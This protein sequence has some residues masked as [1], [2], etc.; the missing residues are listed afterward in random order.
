[1]P[2]ASRSPYYCA[3]LICVLNF[4]VLQTNKQTNKQTKRRAHVK[5]PPWQRK[6]WR[7]GAHLAAFAAK[8]TEY[9]RATVFPARVASSKNISPLATVR[10]LGSFSTIG[11]GRISLLAAVQ[12]TW[13]PAWNCGMSV[14]TGGN[15]YTLT[16]SQQLPQ[17]ALTRRT[18]N[19]GACSQ[20]A[21]LLGAAAPMIADDSSPH[22][23]DCLA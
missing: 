6:S 12:S 3:P 15:T 10:S 19:L 1:M 9:V 13:T 20:H 16:T 2:E 23:N 8:D 11:E 21:R 14:R 22:W 17:T 18:F 5:K 7:T 4:P